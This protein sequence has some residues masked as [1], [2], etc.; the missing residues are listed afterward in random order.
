MVEVAAA[1]KS[2]HQ[3]ALFKKQN[4]RSELRRVRYH[5]PRCR[6]LQLCSL[7]HSKVT[8]SSVNITFN[9]ALELTS[10]GILMASSD[11]EEIPPQSM[12]SNSWLLHRGNPSW[13]S[14]DRKHMVRVIA[15][16][17]GENIRGRAG[18]GKAAAALAGMLKPS[19]NTSTQLSVGVEV[20]APDRKQPPTVTSTEQSNLRTRGNYCHCKNT[21][22]VMEENIRKQRLWWEAV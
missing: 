10:S 7:L 20:F 6:V 3:T 14:A 15:S 2:A 11:M 4:R 13:F 17:T 8:N 21:D 19:S 22:R 1:V 9:T 16:A 12:F 5:Q 18:W